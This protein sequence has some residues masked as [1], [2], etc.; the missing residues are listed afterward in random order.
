MA[1]RE[2]A[3]TFKPPV[4]R[5]KV[6][7]KAVVR[8]RRSP[9]LG[10]FMADFR[11]G[12]GRL[13]ALTR[14]MVRAPSRPL[15][16]TAAS[17]ART[18]HREIM[19]TLER[20]LKIIEKTAPPEIRDRVVTAFRS[21]AE[22]AIHMGV[23]QAY[24]QLVEASKLVPSKA[25]K[26]NQSPAVRAL[27]TT[28]KAIRSGRLA[29]LPR[30]TRV[31]ARKLLK[32]VFASPRALYPSTTSQRAA[33]PTQT[34]SMIAQQ[35]M[36]PLVVQ[37][38][39]RSY[40]NSEQSKTYIDVIK[41]ARR[42][43]LVSRSRNT[44]NV[45]IDASLRSD[46]ATLAP[47]LAGSSAPVLAGSSAPA[48]PQLRPLPPQATAALVRAIPNFE[49]EGVAGA[50]ADLDPSA[51]KHTL[52]YEPG[53]ESATVIGKNHGLL[54]DADVPTAP[55][56]VGSRPMNGGPSGAE[57]RPTRVSAPTSTSA[58]TAA[59]NE[60]NAPASGSGGPMTMT[61]R[62]SIDGLPDFIA[63]VEARLQGLEE[64]VRT[65]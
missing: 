64:L 34:A 60:K 14:R 19:R 58:N 42:Q 23:P 10:R 28:V 8:S 33:A 49:G 31:A 17:T 48:R 7:P 2:D 13:K 55:A 45:N 1:E 40:E 44:P 46:S 54:T 61:G 11:T 50:Y 5:S 43:P 3:A 39:M 47:V 25:L 35:R 9:D 51:R 4:S 32:R 56:G 57:S 37:G 65:Q 63:T 12:L 21:K 41:A 29:F 15:R 30:K 6:S 16:P 18:E 38:M 24:A 27:L 20:E 53:E 26:A 52:S 59:V 62:L 22:S 36:L